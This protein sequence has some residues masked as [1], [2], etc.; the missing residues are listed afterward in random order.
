MMANTTKR[1]F[2]DEL[3]REAIALW[4]TNVRIQTG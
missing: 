2:T 1:R 3:K 4:E